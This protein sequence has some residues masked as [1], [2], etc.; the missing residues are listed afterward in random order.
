MHQPSHLSSK[1][2]KDGEEQKEC[3]LMESILFKGAPP[4][5]FTFFYWPS[6]IAREA[7]V[8]VIGARHIAVQ[9]MLG[10]KQA[11]CAISSFRGSL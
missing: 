10:R 3:L 5:D 4:D 6:L 8:C 2:E 7:D 11:G 9:N 1:Q